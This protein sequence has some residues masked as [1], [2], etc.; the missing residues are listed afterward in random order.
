[1]N[2]PAMDDTR[3][4]EAPETVTAQEWR[5]VAVPFGLGL[6]LLGALF[7]KEV[8]AAVQTWDASTAYN[9]CFLVIPIVL[10]LLWDRRFDLTGIP[11]RPTPAVLLFGLP[12]AA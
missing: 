2:A 5:R 10:Y 9:H 6:L 8:I 11:A 4:V 12:L 1:M 7:N 3:L